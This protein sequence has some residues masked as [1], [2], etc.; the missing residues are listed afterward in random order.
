MQGISHPLLRFL[1]DLYNVLHHAIATLI[2]HL[3][4]CMLAQF[5]LYRK[6]YPRLL[7][8]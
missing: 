5:K 6:E 8:F 4:I 3:Y 1:N 7:T 2:S